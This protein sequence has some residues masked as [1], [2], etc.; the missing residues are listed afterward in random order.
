MRFVS[1]L[2]RF[3]HG[4]RSANA[5]YG[6]PGGIHLCSYAGRSP[7]R[8][9]DGSHRGA[10][11]GMLVVSSMF[12]AQLTHFGMIIAINIMIIMFKFN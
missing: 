11:R 1:L 6:C 2:I 10:R 9:L 12:I 3:R 4:R 7:C 5:V 8:N